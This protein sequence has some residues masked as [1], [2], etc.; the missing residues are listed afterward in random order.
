MDSGVQ[1]PTPTAIR[2]MNAQ[3][4]ATG[5]GRIHWKLLCD[6]SAVRREAPGGDAG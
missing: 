1:V 2:K 6:G 4:V 3:S 5:G